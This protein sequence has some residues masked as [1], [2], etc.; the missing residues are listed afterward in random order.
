MNRKLENQ[1]DIWDKLAESW[2]R[3]RQKPF[4]DIK[5]LLERISNLKKG[6]ILDVGC[7]NCRNLLIFAKKGFEC[8]GIDFSKNML[9]YAKEFCS[10]NKIK[11]NLKYGLAEKIPFK[12]NSFDYVLS[13][14]VLHHLNTKEL[15]EKAVEEIYRVLKKKGIALISAWNKFPLCLFIKNKYIKWKVK[16]KIYYRYYYFFSYWEL[17]RLLKKFNFRILNSSG[18]LNKNIWFLIEK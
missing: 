3:L 2:A 18:W 7:G 13:I 10:K 1:K 5:N 12:D 4:R 11:V 17:K 6:K 16:D 8:Y 9:K 15:R 14:A